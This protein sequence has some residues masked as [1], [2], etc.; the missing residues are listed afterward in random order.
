MSWAE[1]AI[2]AVLPNAPSL[3]HPGRNRTLLKKKRDRLL[4]YLY[5]KQKIDASTY[6]LAL[7][8]PLPGEPL[9][10]PGIAPHLVSYFY[11]TQKGIY[12]VSSIDKHIQQQ[13]ESVL[14]RRNDEFVRSDIKHIAALVID[15]RT[16]QVLA[17]CGNIHTGGSAEGSQV[18]IIRSKRSTGSILK[19]FLYYA[20]LQEGTIDRLL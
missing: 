8:E 14:E 5:D 16:N 9:P 2:L 1:A 6:E 13:V 10:L 17:Y 19:P 15:I 3:I 12:V 11:Q 7:S 18:D 20:A 4:R